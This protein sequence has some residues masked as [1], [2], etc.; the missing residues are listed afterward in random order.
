M[1]KD[2]K[3]QFEVG[4]VYEMRFIGDSELKPW[5]ICVKRTATTVSF[6]EFK[7]QN[8][9]KIT[10]KIKASFDGH[11]MIFDGNYSMAPSIKSDKV[12]Y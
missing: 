12:V 2:M 3:T 11:E 5:F 1:R 8:G 7:K 6:E 9:E 10:R 4:N